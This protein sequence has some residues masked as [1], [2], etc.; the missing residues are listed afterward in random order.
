MRQKR[1]MSMLP[2]NESVSFVA[3]LDASTSR[4]FYEE[5]LGLKLVAD[6]L[7]ALVFDLNGH[8][9]RIAKVDELFPAAHTVL[10]WHVDKIEETVNSLVSRGVVF[11]V[12]D[13]MQQDEFGI[14]VSPSGAKVAWFKDP[15]GNNLSITQL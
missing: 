3:T 2:H 7:F 4:K 9:L 5:R 8:V 11:E 1:L 13:G 15:D 14:W 6:E 10:G 12:Y